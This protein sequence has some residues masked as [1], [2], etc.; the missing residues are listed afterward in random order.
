MKDNTLLFPGWMQDSCLYKNYTCFNLWDTEYFEPSLTNVKYLLGHS[1]GCC[2]A[3]LNWKKNPEA[4]VILFNPLISK[5]SRIKLIYNF[6]VM[7]FSSPGAAK[8]WKGSVKWKYLPIAIKNAIFF[9][10]VDIL[11]IIKEIPKDKLIIVRGKSD[12]YFCD[13]DSAVILC[14]SKIPFIELDGAN[15]F[16]SPSVNNLVQQLIK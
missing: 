7:M 10:R 4:T 12:K 11:K 8:A 14:H 5:K 13:L 1:M 16:W 9:R 15:H 2:P 6:I 3:V